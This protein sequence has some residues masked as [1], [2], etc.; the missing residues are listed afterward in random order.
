MQRQDD[1]QM[2]HLYAMPSSQEADLIGN[3]SRSVSVLTSSP[4]PALW[5]AALIK[6]IASLDRRSSVYDVTESRGGKR[7]DGLWANGMKLD[8][9]KTALHAET[10]WT[11]AT[12][13]KSRKFTRDERTV[14]SRCSSCKVLV[15][16]AATNYTVRWDTDVMYNR[17]TITAPLG[18]TSSSNDIFVRTQFETDYC[19][20]HTTSFCSD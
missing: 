13:R 10:I 17:Y 4:C 15:S 2:R 19:G 11:S 12:D 9:R 6:F 8:G 3:T 16:V 20:K 7:G 14:V 5:S 1:K 18:T